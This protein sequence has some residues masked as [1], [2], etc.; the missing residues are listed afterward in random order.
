[1]RSFLSEYGPPNKDGWLRGIVGSGIP[2]DNNSQEKIFHT[3]KR[4]LMQ[5]THG[6]RRRKMGPP[7]LWATRPEN[8]GAA[9]LGRVEPGKP[10]EPPGPCRV[11]GWF[12]RLCTW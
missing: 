11:V 4:T 9:T 2:T 1:M 7:A 6:H 5:T 8:S 10:F 3:F 12:R